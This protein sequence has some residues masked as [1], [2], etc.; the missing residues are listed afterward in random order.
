MNNRCVRCVRAPQPLAESGRVRLPRRRSL[1]GTL[2]VTILI[3]RYYY[4]IILYVVVVVVVVSR[5]LVPIYFSTPCVLR[6]SQSGS[7]VRFEIKLLRINNQPERWN[8]SPSNCLASLHR[9]RITVHIG[10]LPLFHLLLNLLHL[11]FFK[12]VFKIN[13]VFTSVC[14]INCGLVYMTFEGYTPLDA[15]RYSRILTLHVVIP[16]K[17]T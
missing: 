3:R 8:L 17:F 14:S 7:C 16:S 11:F 9:R 1:L 15:T 5:A 4:D 6:S 2:H 10:H 13:N 12:F